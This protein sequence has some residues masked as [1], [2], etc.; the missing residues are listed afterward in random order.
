MLFGIQT[1]RRLTLINADAS[2]EGRVQRS[3]LQ[4]DSKIAIIIKI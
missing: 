1:E 4:R 2:P 3:I